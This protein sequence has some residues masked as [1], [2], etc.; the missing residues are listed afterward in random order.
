[1]AGTGLR[2]RVGT[3]LQGQLDSLEQTAGASTAGAITLGIALG[4]VTVAG[5][6][7]LFI[8]VWAVLVGALH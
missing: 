3:A 6:I 4:V 1:M 2:E 5:G 7:G 8:A